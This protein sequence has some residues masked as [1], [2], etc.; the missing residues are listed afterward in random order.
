M[1]RIHA[2]LVLGGV[3]LAAAVLTLTTPATAQVRRNVGNAPPA[4]AESQARPT[5]PAAAAPSIPPARG[6][7][8]ETED[9]QERPRP[10]V[11]P[12]MVA[13]IVE[14]RGPMWLLEQEA[15]R[16]EL[17]ITDAQ[18]EKLKEVNSKMEETR[19]ESMEQFR[20]QMR[21]QFGQQQGGPGGAPGGGAPGG[22]GPGGPGGGF[23]GGP[24]GFPGGPGGFPGGFPGGPG[25]G[26]GGFPGGDA[27]RTMMQQMQQQAD[28]AVASVLSKDQVKRLKQ[29]I[30]QAKGPMAVT[31][32]ELQAALQLM[33]VQI[34]QIAMIK[35]EMET[36][37]QVTNNARRELFGAVFGR[38]RNQGGQQEQGGNQQGG[39]EPPQQGSGGQDDQNDNNRGRGRFQIDPETQAKMDELQSQSE[40][41]EKEAIK[42][43]GQVL[44][45]S[46]ISQY[47][48]LIG[49]KF[50]FSQIDMSTAGRGF[51][52]GRGGFGGFGGFG[53]GRG[54]RGGR[55]G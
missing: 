10:P 31:E 44:T 39:N 20:E 36:K 33:P 8:E 55:G 23:P 28:M 6:S 34:E 16:Q 9:D 22:R 1:T 40:L 5:E 3:A 37:Q 17:K 26:P 13:R 35:Q 30:L 32:P 19:R 41:Y 24:G 27:F 14:M 4:P 25:G 49:E 18:F 53:G 43:I 11:D 21:Q 7:Q 42:K 2:H 12:E 52:G 15:V 45:R 46:Q 51:G 50:D 54:G 48:K 38:G 29:I 47:N